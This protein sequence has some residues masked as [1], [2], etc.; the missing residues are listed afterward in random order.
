MKKLTAIGITFIFVFFSFISCEKKPTAPRAGAASVD[1]MLSLVP[2]DAMGVFFIDFHRAMSTEMASKTIKEDKNYQKYQEFIEM[3]GIDP[4]KD[5]YFVTLAVMEV[6]EKEKTKASAIINLKYDKEKL[7]SLA[8]EKATEE[9]Q[10]ILE[11]EYN[12]MKIY[13]IEQEKGEAP[14]F[15]FIDDSNI[16]AGDEVGVRSC[17][18]VLQKRRENVFK[19][20]E[21]TD[22]IETTNKG[23]M[24]WGAFLIPQEMMNKVADQNPMLGNLKAVQA[25]SMYFDYKDKNILSEIKVMSSDETK[26][27]QIAD[28]LNGVKAMGGMVSAKKPEIGELI[29][30]IEITSS[31]DHVKIYANIPEELINRLKEMKEKEEGEL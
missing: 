15:S 8:K 24:I 1:D 21:L 9:G 23:A 29:N 7:L 27:Q 14:K 10:E 31:P 19:N 6:I 22:L 26:N 17:I 2:D 16:V 4:Q 18:D 28:L 25:T 20:E 3:T 12:G 11:E 30:K 13:S 5:V